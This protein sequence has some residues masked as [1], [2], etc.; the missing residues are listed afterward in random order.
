MKADHLKGGEHNY[1]RWAAT[2]NNADPARIEY[3]TDD[4]LHWQLIGNNISLSSGF[5]QWLTPDTF[6][7][8]LLRIST[9]NHTFLSDTFSISSRLKASTGF[10]CSDSFLLAWNKPTGVNNFVVYALGEK[11]LTP[12]LTTNDTAVVLN[13]SVSSTLYYTVSPMLKTGYEGLKAYTFN[14]TAQGTACYIKSFLVDLINKAAN[15]SIELGTSY[16]LQQ[17]T[18]EKLGISGYTSL[19][20]I[21]PV[22]ALQYQLTDN[23]LTRGL[24]TYRLKIN[25]TDG[26]AVY[27]QPETVYN[28]QDAGYLVYPNPIPAASLLNILSALPGNT[29]I[30]LYNAAGQQVLQK[31]L[32]DLHEKVPLLTLQKVFI[33]TSS[34]RKGRRNRQEVYWYIKTKKPRKAAL[35]FLNLKKALF[36][37]YFIY[38]GFLAIDRR[39]TQH[40]YAAFYLPGSVVLDRSLLHLLHQLLMHH[41]TCSTYQG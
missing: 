4:G 34:A 37:Y 1:L 11:Y 13:K 14:Y 22:T 17:I 15:L 10:N 38:K 39:N 7:T 9:N 21:T 8:A 30:I 41:L 19:Q 36:K 33:S 29:S 3:S 31:K 20:L 16:G 28:L 40:I 18:V 26:T 32:T 27:S 23:S 24:N 2:F 5:Y 12:L 35:M 6:S 25:R